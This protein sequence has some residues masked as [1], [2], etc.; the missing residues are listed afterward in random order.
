MAKAELIRMKEIITQHGWGQC[1]LRQRGG[2]YDLAGAL[3]AAFGYDVPPLADGDE[4]NETIHSLVE[5][6]ESHT[7]FVSDA[8]KLV[9]LGL[10]DFRIHTSPKDMC[11]KLMHLNDEIVS[12]QENAIIL[13]DKA[14]ARS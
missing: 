3:M 11:W 5:A 9:K 12:G 4:Y 13:I 8:F 1:Y 2:E 7:G 14:I 6:F 10:D